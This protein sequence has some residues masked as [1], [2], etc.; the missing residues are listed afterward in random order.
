MIIRSAPYVVK[1]KEA[2]VA[3]AGCSGYMRFKG[4]IALPT[5]PFALR[6]KR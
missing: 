6:H 5:L 2:Y 3:G 4:V 1:V